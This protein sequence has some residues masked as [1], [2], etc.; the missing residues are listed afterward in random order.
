MEIQTG[1]RLHRDRH[2]RR[3]VGRGCFRHRAGGDAAGDG[4]VMGVGVRHV[5]P[6]LF[7]FDRLG[8]RVAGA[9]AA[10]HIIPGRA[11]KGLE[12]VGD[13]ARRRVGVGHDRVDL[14]ALD[15]VVVAVQAGQRKR[16]V[17]DDVHRHGKI[18]TEGLGVGGAARRGV[19]N[20]GI[21]V[22]RKIAV[23]VGRRRHRQRGRER[24][25]LRGADHPVAALRIQCA[26]RE[27]RAGWEA[28]EI[29]RQGIG[30]VGIGQR[31]EAGQGDTA[32]LEPVIGVGDRQIFDRVL[33]RGVVAFAVR[34]R[35]EVTGGGAREAGGRGGDGLARRVVLDHEGLVRA[36]VGDADI[37][38]CACVERG[39]DPCL[40][41]ARIIG[42]QKGAGIADAPVGDET[43]AVDGAA[44][45]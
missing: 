43:D 8:R 38:E 14:L 33:V 13:A 36:V 4:I 20:G 42:D 6:Q 29:Q 18:V 21:D 25:D 2:R 16:R 39:V 19:G 15:R 9:G 34:D 12:G 3:V 24:G 31:G 27:R 26:C 23:V 41:M 28:R 7:A 30:A 11:V 45:G 32:V 40:L 44:I 37:V 22:Q 35:D 17:V 5:D 10:L 1:W